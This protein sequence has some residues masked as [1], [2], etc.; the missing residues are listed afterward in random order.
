MSALVLTAAQ[1]TPPV[2]ASAPPG[3][4]SRSPSSISR[5]M[6]FSVPDAASVGRR[7]LQL[8]SPRRRQPVWVAQELCGELYWRDEP[9]NSARSNVAQPRDGC[10]PPAYRHEEGCRGK[11]RNSRP[12]QHAL[13]FICRWRWGGRDHTA[14]PD[15]GL[16][17]AANV[18]L[19]SRP[20]RVE[21][22]RTPATAIPSIATSHDACPGC[23]GRPPG[24]RRRLEIVDPRKPF[25]DPAS[26]ADLDMPAGRG[27]RAARR[28][29][30]RGWAGRIMG[31]DRHSTTAPTTGS[32]GS[33]P[34]LTVGHFS[35]STAAHRSTRQSKNLGGKRG[36]PA[37]QCITNLRAH[38]PGDLQA[39]ADPFP[40]P[41][42]ACAWSW[43]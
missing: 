31:Q 30:S 20:S 17:H 19:E 42:P 25:N 14:E 40:H 33:T 5:A 15:H 11:P 23:G 7:A 12:R 9:R 13:P 38:C 43:S 35:R 26:A 21:R 1:F 39:S 32:W 27:R 6:D 18:A 2:Q 10:A 34:D 37:A 29:C 3:S 8:R 16:R 41:A 22:V 24:S 36:G 4:A 28:P